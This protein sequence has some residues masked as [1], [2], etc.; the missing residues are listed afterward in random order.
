M[1]GE[2]GMQVPVAGQAMDTSAGD[3]HSWS[4]GVSH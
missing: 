1:T 2:Q 4:G 3:Q